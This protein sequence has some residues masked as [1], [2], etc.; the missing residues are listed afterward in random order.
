MFAALA[1]AAQAAVPTT[2]ALFILDCDDAYGL[3]LAALREGIKAVRVDA[4][5]EILTKLRDIAEQSGAMVMT[6]WPEDI[7][8]M[9][10]FPHPD[11]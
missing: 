6:D 8:D 9:E 4:A 2:Q 7:V 10:G 1:A 11:R 5:P 3:A